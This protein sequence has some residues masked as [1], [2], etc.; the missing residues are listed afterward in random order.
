MTTL[1]T[2]ATGFVGLHLTRLLVEKRQNIRA[3]V[4]PSSQRRFI[5]DL[6]VEL[7]NG[8]LRDRSSLDSALKGVTR[9]FHVA[10]DYRLWSKNPSELYQSNVDGTRNLIE[11]SRNAGVERFVYTSTVGTIA[12]PDWHGL[13]D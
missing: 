12:V 10:A 8:D 1:I 6:P 3:L 7:V 4:R 5:Q 2:G 11:A 9:V 13:P